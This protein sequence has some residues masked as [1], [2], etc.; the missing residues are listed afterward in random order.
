M[1]R[2]FDG[3]Q[4][5][6]KNDTP[7]ISSALIDGGIRMV[8]SGKFCLDC[9]KQFRES[10]RFAPMRPGF[11]YVVDLTRTTCLDSYALRAL[12]QLRDLAE[13]ER[14]TVEIDVATGGAAESVI[15]M[16]RFE[17]LFK[18]RHLDRRSKCP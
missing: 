15:E 16:A 3:Y 18:I 6:M 11:R 8:V 13:I 10:V 14:A 1:V 4:K 2:G 12:L 5:S 7:A 9:Y 17:E